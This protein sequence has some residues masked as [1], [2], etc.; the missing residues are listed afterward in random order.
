MARAAAACLVVLACASWLCAGESKVRIRTEGD[1]DKMIA[2]AKI[3]TR[4][5]ERLAPW[6]SLR[7]EQRRVV[8]GAL[9]RALGPGTVRAKGERLSLVIDVDRAK[10]FD[11]IVR[12]LALRETLGDASR[13]SLSCKVDWK[14]GGL[15]AA[16]AATVGAR[17]ES[18][19]R[20]YLL[21]CQLVEAKTKDKTARTQV[22]IEGT[23][24]RASNRL[25]LQGLKVTVRNPVTKE[26]SL[27]SLTSS[28]DVARPKLDVA[29]AVL[30]PMP[31]T[32][33][34]KTSLTAVVAGHLRV[35]GEAAGM[36]ILRVLWTPARVAPK[37]KGLVVCPGCGDR[38]ARAFDSCPACEAP[39]PR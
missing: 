8:L 20:A 30:V 14:G 17:L 31:S 18:S 9:M 16:E 32:K 29:N 25:E 4:V 15:K 19:V 27:V 36:G 28:G 7:G 13:F 33:T 1:A 12:A 22:T 26:L 35:I 10:A 38:V 37:A 5:Y 11:A 34:K 6:A 24:R 21:A 2:R 3:A 23:L 39:L